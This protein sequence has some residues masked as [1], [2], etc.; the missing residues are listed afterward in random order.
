[1]AC[2]VRSWR[3]SAGVGPRSA[4]RAMKVLAPDRGAACEGTDG[5]PGQ[6]VPSA[7]GYERIVAGP[8]GGITNDGA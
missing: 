1:M 7:I 8:D 2:F 3:P 4:A 6:C 5:D